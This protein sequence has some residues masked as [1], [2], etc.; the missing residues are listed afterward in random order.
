MV[1]RLRLL[2]LLVVEVGD[3]EDAA[4]AATIV[5]DKISELAS[6]SFRAAVAIFLAPSSSSS[7]DGV[8]ETNTPPA[9][10]VVGILRVC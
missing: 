2:L 4:A 5:M 6:G 9:L 10:R 8:P 3:V 1:C 7:K